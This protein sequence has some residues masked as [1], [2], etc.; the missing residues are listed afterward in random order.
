MKKLL[1]FCIG[2]LST[3]Y[4]LAQD[5]TD[6]IRYSIDEIQGTAR[7]RAMSGAFGA[8]GGDMSGV[9]INPAGSA[10]FNNSHASVSIGVFNK[11][12]D[13]N[14]FNGSNSDSDSNLDLN[15]LGATFVFTNSNPNSPWKKFTLG[16]AYDNT[17]N[18]NNEWRASG[19]NTTSIDSYFLAFTN[20]IEIPFG[21]LKL[22]PGE[23]IE[24][25]YSDIGT[26]PDDGYSIQQAFLGYW[27][28]II[29]P[30][31]LDDNTNNNETNYVSNISPGNF[32]QNYLY[33]ETGYNGKLAFNF[34]TDYDDKFFFGLNLNTHFINYE[35]FTSLNET[36]SNAGSVVNSLRF[37]NLLSTTGSGFSFQLG[38]IVKL[39]PELR[40]GVSYNSPTWYRVS[41]ELVQGIN[42]NIADQD[43]RY[44]S[45]IINIYPEYKLKTPGKITGSLAYVFGKQGLLSFDYSVKDYSNAKFKPTSDP[46]FSDLNNDISNALTSAASYKFGGEYR[47]KQFSFRGGYRFEE[48]PYKDDMRLGDL[49]GYSLG[50]GYT[51]G[52]FNLDVAFSQAERETNHQLY[53]VGL[54]DSAQV[55]TK[56]TD[57]IITLGFRI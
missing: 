48:S 9:S 6:A 57:V 34:A 39:T 10:I 21:I 18:L 20:T 49:T 52:D 23:F 56:F 1:M 31:N 28:G 51:F 2:M 4:I 32:N 30:E 27:S 45:D 55:Q 35:K 26:I 53:N 47:H 7:F 33:S 13:V 17:A 3:S 36:N 40:A 43:I 44:I 11:N 37:E 15:Q 46:S 42:S 12:N 14:Y 50:L 25:A 24:E 19:T 41:E 8:L 16:A 5:V 22:Q 38:T 54:T 29:D